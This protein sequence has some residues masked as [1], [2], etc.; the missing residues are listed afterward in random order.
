[1]ALG[2]RDSQTPRDYHML[3]IICGKQTPCKTE[4]LLPGLGVDGHHIGWKACIQ[5]L[6]WRATVVLPAPGSIPRSRNGNETDE[7]NRGI[8]DGGSG[9]R[10]VSRHA[11]KWDGKDGPG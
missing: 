9:D 6:C 2:Q 3:E 5:M 4:L 7:N 11:E 8:V 1:M 10:E